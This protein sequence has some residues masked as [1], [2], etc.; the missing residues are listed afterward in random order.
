MTT[1]TN[2]A[3]DLL[4]ELAG[5]GWTFRGIAA[6]LGVRPETLTRW[7]NGTSSVDPL[8]MAKLK[9]LLTDGE[10]TGDKRRAINRD[11]TAT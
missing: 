8:T 11:A 6:R 1:K 3:A 5:L 10:I 2:P 9:K 7:K 4:L